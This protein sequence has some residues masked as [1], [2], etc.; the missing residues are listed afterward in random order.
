MFPFLL[1]FSPCITVESV[2]QSARDVSPAALLDALALLAEILDLLFGEADL[3]PSLDDRNRRGDRAVVADDLLDLEC[4]LHVLR[5][6]HAV[7]DDRRLEGDDRLALLE[8]LLD[9]R[10]EVHGDVQLSALHFCKKALSPF[11]TINHL[12]NILP[13]PI[14]LI[15]NLRGEEECAAEIKRE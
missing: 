11:Q 14:S 5:V 1:C 13:K 3:D 6:F 15:R 12:L 9:V 2:N 7:R 8:S 10:K 4:G